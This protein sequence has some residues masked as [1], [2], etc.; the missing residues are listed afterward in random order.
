MADSGEA[1]AYPR[2]LHH[3][4]PVWVDAGVYF[5]IRIR[6]AQADRQSLVLPELGRMLLSA[7]QNYHER[8]RWQALLFLLM[9]DHT[10]AL[11]AFPADRSMSRIVGEW[12]HYVERE[13][14]VEWQGNFFD[15]RIR[16][17]S[18]LLEK[19]VYIL[20][21]PVVKGLCNREA[22]WPWV[23]APFAGEEN[24]R[25]ARV[26]PQDGGARAPHEL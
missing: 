20:R 16:N 19:Y 6:V 10:H 15:H 18:E 4:V 11:L 22:D 13:T 12:K 24:P 3:T 5:H 23:W 7:V 8:G 1:R 9:P 17:Q 26:P 21:N 25:G 14:D 2:R